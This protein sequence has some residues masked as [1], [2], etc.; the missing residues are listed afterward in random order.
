L[1]VRGAA[2]QGFRDHEVTRLPTVELA[3]VWNGGTL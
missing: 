3:Q 2:P 1:S